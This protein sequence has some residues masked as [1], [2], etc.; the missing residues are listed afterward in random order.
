MSEAPAPGWYP[1]P[2]GRYEVRYWD[3]RSWTEHIA[4]PTFPG[5]PGR[6]GAGGPVAAPLAGLG[7]RLGGAALDGL[8]FVVTLGIGWIVWA[9]VTFSRGQTPAKSMLGTRVVS[10][11]TGRV[12]GWSQMFLRQVVIQGGLNLLSL[13]LF[14]IPSLVATGL[15]FGGHRRQTG[16]DRMAGTVVVV[17]PSGTTLARPYGVPPAG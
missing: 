8:L 10:Q 6:A 15:I 1:D 11:E 3:G 12:V 9:A 2:S 17:D 5:D 16:W 14:G 4:H 7:A 13:F